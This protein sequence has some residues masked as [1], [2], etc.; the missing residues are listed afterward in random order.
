MTLVRPVISKAV[1][2]ILV[3]E[4]AVP[5]FTVRSSTPTAPLTV[6]LV[7]AASIVTLEPAPTL[8][9][10]LVPAPTA[11]LLIVVRVEAS[12]TD[13]VVPPKLRTSKPVAAFTTL[14]AAALNA[15]F[16][17]ETDSVSVPAVPPFSCVP[18]VMASKLVCVS[19]SV[20]LPAPPVN[21]NAAA[22]VAPE[23]ST[24][25]LPVAVDALMV[26]TPANDSTSVR[27][28]SPAM[29]SVSSLALPFSRVTLLAAPDAVMVA[30]V[31]V[32]FATSICTTP[33]SVVLVPTLFNVRLVASD[34]VTLAVVPPV[35]AFTLVNV[36]ACVALVLTVKFVALTRAAA[37]VS[38]STEVRP[39]MV[40]TFRVVALVARPP[41]M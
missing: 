2:V 5:I 13:V 17:A 40:E 30:D 25:T 26:F 18:A 6:V 1:L 31:A 23:V 21:L 4:A 22:N 11:K 34:N 8:E 33:L 14:V 16:V 15:R 28:L 32:V 20:S 37:G 10:V 27:F 3:V 19:F 38:I 9:I 12:T 35:T 41:L 24:D 29:F 36:T 7:V 39:E